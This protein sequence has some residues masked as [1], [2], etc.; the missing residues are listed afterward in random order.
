MTNYTNSEQSAIDS[1]HSVF[2]AAN[3]TEELQQKEILAIE[4][5]YIRP[6][7]SNTD[8]SIVADFYNKGQYVKAL[9]WIA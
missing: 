8:W 4:L 6:H 2:A 5:G 3:K 9:N 7:W 1:L